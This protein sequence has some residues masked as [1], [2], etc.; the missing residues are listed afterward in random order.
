MRKATWGQIWPKGGKI[1]IKKKKKQLS[2]TAQNR[3]ADLE[4]T[5]RDKVTKVCGIVRYMKKVIEKKTKAG[6]K[7]DPG[8]P[9]EG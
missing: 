3:Y 6:V 4:E 9:F 1:E 8:W 2:P 5:C 7:F